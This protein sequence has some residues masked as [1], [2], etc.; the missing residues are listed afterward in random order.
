[1]ARDL[2]GFQPQDDRPITAAA[3]AMM[4]EQVPAP[5]K[6]LQLCKERGKVPVRVQDDGPGLPR[7]VAADSCVWDMELKVKASRLYAAFQA[8]ADK[9]KVAPTLIPDSARFSV[10]LSK[11][12]GV[13]CEKSN[14]VRFLHLPAPDALERRLQAAGM[15][16]D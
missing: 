8:Y 12:A 16:E 6:F 15:W 3:K 14:G 2:R 10:M 9:T 13:R 7:Q 11:H 5:I 1:M 4:A